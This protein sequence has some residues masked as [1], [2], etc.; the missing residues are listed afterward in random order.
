MKAVP[1]V[2][3]VG[4]M[5]AGKTTIG[6]RLAARLAAGF[7]DLDEDIT[8]RF[9]CGV[10]EV[11]RQHGEAVFRAAERDRL[12][13]ALAGP[14][15]VI[16]V[17][18]GAWCDER[19]RALAYAAGAVVVFL[20]VPWSELWRRL[21]AVAGDRPLL[22]DQRATHALFEARL[23]AYSCADATVSLAAGTTPDEAATLVHAAVEEVA[24]AT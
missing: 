16:A 14:E 24:C 23:P 6:R 9:G 1:S 2:I 13:A 3:L 11:F 19:N 12:A 20:D 22:D 5:A 8:A 7:V 18:G 4:F 21:S 17:G 15:A 10:G